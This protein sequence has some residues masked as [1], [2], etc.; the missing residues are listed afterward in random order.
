VGTII[1]NSFVT[2]AND[3]DE[4]KIRELARNWK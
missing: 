3:F 1:D 4:A 2:E